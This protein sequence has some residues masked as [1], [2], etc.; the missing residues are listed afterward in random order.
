MS[1]ISIPIGGFS[2]TEG[3]IGKTV[4]LD[5]LEIANIRLEKAK[6]RI[7]T[8]F[9][10]LCSQFMLIRNCVKQTE[11]VFTRI[12]GKIS[13]FTFLQYINYINNNRLAELNMHWVNSP[14]GQ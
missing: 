14:N 13:A 4:Q 10:Q 1:N 11:G 6:K 5:L 3:Y 2:V 12:I 7:E 8:T 9:S